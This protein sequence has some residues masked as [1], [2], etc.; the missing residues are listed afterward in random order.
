M[1]PDTDL[2]KLEPSSLALSWSGRVPLAARI[3]AINVLPLVLLAGS[4]FYL[5][6]FRERLIEERRTQAE[7]E[8]KLVAQSI[9]ADDAKSLPSLVSKLGIGSKVR[10]RIIDSE[11]SI[12]A[13]NWARGGPSFTFTDLGQESWQ[14]QAAF[15]LDEVIDWLVGTELP[16]RFVS[17]ETSL[18]PAPDGA[19]LSLAEDRTH[20]IEARAAVASLPGRTIVTL[21]NARDIR[22][23]VRAERAT[24]GNMIGLALIF[25]IFLSLFL[26]RTIVRPLKALAHAAM[27]V[28]YG[29]ARE[30]D[31]PR[32]P[33]RRDEIG[34]LARSVFDMTHELRD[35]IDATE[36][37]AADVAHE[38]KNPLASLSSAVES[39]KRVK[40]RDLQ[41]QLHGV[42]SDDVRRLDRLI[43]DVAD[44]SRIDAKIA[45]ARFD[46]VDV[47]AMIEALLAAREE[48]SLNGSCTVAFARPQAGSAAV[49]GDPSQLLRV[50]ENLLDNAVSFSPNDAVIRIAATA[51]DEVVLVT[52][53]D[54]GP[55]IPEKAHEAIFERFHSD[56]PEAEFGRHSGLGLAIAR[57]IVEAHDGTIEA[58]DRGRGQQGA[59]FVVTLPKLNK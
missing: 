31:V 51:T 57:T 11:G 59:S 53:D 25:S 35:R 33:A 52:V 50:F 37:F 48:R 23:F 17:N 1:E 18:L 49:R 42:I 29:F 32:L 45:R 36:A 4:F 24:L 16:P 12:V 55:G 58:R 8:A 15:R 19:T 7:N 43:T 46:R 40:R 26:A 13:D 20:M 30:V 34:M 27:Q 44:L 38:L 3:L 10:I 54:D 2:A 14:K 56:R 6:G 41:N 5:D 39:L 9:G 28:R 47:G 22:R 21:R